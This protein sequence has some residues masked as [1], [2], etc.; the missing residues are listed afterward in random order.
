MYSVVYLHDEAAIK[1]VDFLLADS[2]WL[3]A[4]A[5]LVGRKIGQGHHF[6]LNRDAT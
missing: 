2:E 6:G 1:K 5:L 4:V 3:L